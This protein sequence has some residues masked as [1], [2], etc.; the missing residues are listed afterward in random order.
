MRI[1][2]YH[3]TLLIAPVWVYF[4]LAVFSGCGAFHSPESERVTDGDARDPSVECPAG[5]VKTGD[6]A[7]AV[8]STIVHPLLVESCKSCHSQASRIGPHVAGDPNPDIA[9][10]EARSRYNGSNAS[11]WVRGTD[12]HCQGCR[13]FSNANTK[14][15]YKLALES[16]LKTETTP[17]TCVVQKSDGLPNEPNPVPEKLKFTS[18]VDVPVALTETTFKHVRFALDLLGFPGAIL[19]VGIKQFTPLFYEFGDF[20]LYPGPSP[21]RISGLQVWVISGQETVTSNTLVNL[22]FTAVT[23]STP[24]NVNT[25]PLNVPPLT[26][27][28]V[29]GNKLSTADKVKVSFTGIAWVASECREPALFEINVL[30]IINN[31]FNGANACVG[32][33]AMAGISGGSKFF[34]NTAN[35]KA[36]CFEF[37][38]RVGPTDETSLVVTK[39]LG[40]A[41]PHPAT[42]AS[43]L[44]DPILRWRDQELR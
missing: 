9:Y 31:G 3:F 25:L 29:L 30:P 24:V 42:V 44:L 22:S 20:R 10:P 14:L 12:G 36:L 11:L 26:S 15:D 23:P 21:M 34:M 40:Q 39:L 32:C 2:C 35:V 43:N 7:K 38:R 16:W 8:F 1:G 28:T 17:A 13:V 27:Q 19:D 18:G 37:R 41:P 33:H 6:D 4:C 5:T